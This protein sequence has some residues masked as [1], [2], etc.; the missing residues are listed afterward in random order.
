MSE[1]IIKGRREGF[2]VIYNSVLKDEQLSLK[3][4]GLFAVM[5]SFPETWAYNISGLAARCRVGRDTIRGC[6][7]EL[8]AAG[9]LLREQEH[10]AYGRF[11][12]TTFVL[13]ERKPTQMPPSTEKPSTVKPTT[14]KPLTENR[15]QVKKQVSQET[16]STP[17]TPRGE[18]DT[19]FER[20]WA[21]YPKKMGKQAARRAWD[22]LSPGLDLCREMAAALARQKASRDWTREG[23][24]Y[25][26]YPAT[27]IN[28]RRWEDEI[29][30]TPED[31]PFIRPDDGR[32]GRFL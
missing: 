22:R 7:R 4:I 16:R 32:R 18:S 15:T 11:G 17:S 13:Q 29:A 2:T 23:G 26:P 31:R 19:L 20:F 21:A 1:S 27:W 25:I 8:E 3:T 10:D 14:A 12:G 9:Y 30:D 6:L 28:G 24:R 5:S